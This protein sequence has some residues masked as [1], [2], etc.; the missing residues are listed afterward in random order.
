MRWSE[1]CIP[2]L[3]EEPREAEIPSHKLMLRAGLIK[4]LTSGIYTF[5]PVGLRVIKKIEAIIR[6]ELDAIGARS[7]PHNYG[8]PLTNF[9]AC[10]LA[11]I[12]SG[13]EMAE[14]DESEV[15][16]LDR[17]GYTLQDGR[18]TV[19]PLPGFGLQLD[20]THYERM[21]RE[22]GFDVRL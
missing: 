10:H 22:T 4:K 8:E 14:W 17:S 21:V 12:I 19:P 20:D 11:R 7:A 6:E 5:M 18:V 13:F 9:Y 15:D 16:G 2:T 1:S 3:K